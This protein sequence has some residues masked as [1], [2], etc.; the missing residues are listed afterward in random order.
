MKDLDHVW[1]GQGGLIRSESRDRLSKASYGP[2]GLSRARTVY[3]E[4][5][6]M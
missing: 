5:Y 6:L 3:D 1:S 2:E 4:P